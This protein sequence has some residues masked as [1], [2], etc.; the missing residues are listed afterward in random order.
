MYSTQRGAAFFAL[1]TDFLVTGKNTLGHK[2]SSD[3]TF[4]ADKL[5]FRKIFTA[6]TKWRSKILAIVDLRI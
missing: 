1:P 6:H 4:F 3:R 5:Q 2:A